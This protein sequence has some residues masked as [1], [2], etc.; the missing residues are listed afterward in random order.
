MFKTLSNIMKVQDLRRRII[1]TLLVLIVYRIGAFIPVPNID[2]DILKSI[3]Q[4]SSGGVFG[5]LNTFSGGA[6]FQFSIFA[7]GIMPYITSSIIVQLLSMDVVPRFAQWAKEG[8]VGRKKLA[9]ITRYGTIVLGLIQAYSVAFGFN[10]LYGMQLVLDP[11]FTTYLL[12]AIVLTAGTA[13]LMWLGEQITEYGIGNGISII[14][15]AGIIASIP[16]GI[17]MIYLRLFAESA[18]SA[19]FLNILKVVIIV[20]VVVAIIVGVIFVQQGV[21]KIPVQYTKRVVGRKMYGG[22]STH[23]PLKVNAAGVI[24]VIFASSLLVFPPTIAQFWRGNVVA[25]WIINNLAFTAALGMVL[26]VLLII[27]FTYFYTFV[28]I[29]PVQM[30]EQ[31]KKNGGYIPGIRPGKTTAT[32]LTRVMTRITLS[33]A[34]FLAVIS[35]LPVFFTNLAGLPQQVTIG[36]TSLLIV[37]GVA[38]ETMKQIESQ[39]IKRH[40]KGF[41]NK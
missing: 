28:Q 25:D 30:A 14:I 26:Y 32:Y 3:D 11:G 31:M 8:E 38:L 19:L 27:G 10:R 6:L 7:L 1:F 16:N 20:L 29:N 35:I 17:N 13:F 37:V 40:Y 41:I 21:R 23:I 15:F 39:L 18:D 12:I 2:A 36:G 9:Q 33:G 22:Q 34:I 24:P 5:L 4:S